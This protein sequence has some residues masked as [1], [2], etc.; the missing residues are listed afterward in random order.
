MRYITNQMNCYIKLNLYS[1][2][3]YASEITTQCSG[4]TV[5]FISLSRKKPTKT[6]VGLILI[7][8]N[9]QSYQYI[10]LRDALYALP[11]NL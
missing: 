6:R 3:S 5:Q 7:L 2:E 8:S 10:E 11:A 4:C 1:N 9:V